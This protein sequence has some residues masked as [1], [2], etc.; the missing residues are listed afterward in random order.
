MLDYLKVFPEFETMLRRYTDEER[1]RLFMAMMAYAYRGEEPDFDEDAH[2]WYIWDTI[3]LKIDQCAE[4]LESKRASGKKGGSAKQ[5]EA[6]ESN[7]KHNEAEE[8]NVKHNEAEESTPKQTEAEASKAKQTEADAS[9]TD[10]YK[11]KNKNKSSSSYVPPTPYDDINDDELLRLRQEQQ[12]VETAARRV[13][14]PVSAAGDYDTMDALRAEH[15]A[16]N[17]LK[18]ISRIQGA[19]E[20]SRDWR[21]ISGILRKERASGYTWAEKP[22]NA[23]GEMSH[24]RPEPRSHTRDL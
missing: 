2:E 20:K 14:L 12:D 23:S 24:E 15:G 5:T 1:G 9:K 21:Y 7:V 8:S 6:E 13:G 4:T 18:A 16:D 22:P 17:L 3:K 11:N 10:I 19:T